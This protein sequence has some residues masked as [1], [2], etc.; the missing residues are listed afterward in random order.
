MTNQETFGHT[1]V[2]SLNQRRGGR[3]YGAGGGGRG[4]RGAPQQQQQH[5]F[6][7]GGGFNNAQNNRPSFQANRRPFRAD[8]N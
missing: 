8:F 1:A 3:S 5:R 7:S 6:N 4:P 2:R